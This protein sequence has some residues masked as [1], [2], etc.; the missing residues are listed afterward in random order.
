MA[1][2]YKTRVQQLLQ[3][4]LKSTKNYL[5]EHVD[6]RSLVEQASKNVRDLARK[7]EQRIQEATSK[8]EQSDDVR[9]I[10]RRFLFFF[11]T[12]FM[13]SVFFSSS[14]GNNGKL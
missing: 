8:K 3:D 4:S 7:A 1:E 12:V 2:A 13:I 6:A 5:A 11:S 14:I 10:R 9:K